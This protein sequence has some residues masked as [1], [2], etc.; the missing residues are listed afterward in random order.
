MAKGVMVAHN[1]F[2]IARSYLTWITIRAY[3]QA[4]VRWTTL[5]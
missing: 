4:G 1:A 3:A 5:F 2:G